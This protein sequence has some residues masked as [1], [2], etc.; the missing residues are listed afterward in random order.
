LELKSEAKRRKIFNKQEESSDV[1]K[2]VLAPET[3]SLPLLGKCKLN[4]WLKSL[5]TND[6]SYNLFFLQSV[7]QSLMICNCGKL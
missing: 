4:M 6:F 5:I 3:Q 2:L 1:K 7:S